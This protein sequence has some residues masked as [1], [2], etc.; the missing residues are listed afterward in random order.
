MPRAS[1]TSNP[2]PAEGQVPAGD[3]Q[4]VQQPAAGEVVEGENQSTDNEEEIA[5]EVIA[6]RWG[7]GQRRRKRLEDA[8]YD[9]DA[10]NKKVSEIFNRK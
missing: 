7:R 8:G 5:K 9:V 4:P 1:T 6:G 3:Y 10:V 2:E